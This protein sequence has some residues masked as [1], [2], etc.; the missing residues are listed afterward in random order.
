MSRRWVDTLRDVW[1]GIRSQPG[2]VGLAFTAIAVGI[3]SI[4]VLVT[5]LGGLQERSR[6]IVG[7]LGVNVVGILQH[8]SDP[9]AALEERHASLLAAN[10]PQS[11]VSTVSVLKVPTLG[12]EE[13]LSVVATDNALIDVRQWSLEDGRFLDPWDLTHRERKAVVSKTLSEQWNWKVGNVIM[14]RSTPFEV[15]GVVEVGGGALDGELG[16]AGLMLGERVVFVPK[17]VAPDWK[18]GRRTLP[19]G[20]AVRY[21]SP[22]HRGSRPTVDAIF[23]RAPSSTEFVHAVLTARR[24][25]SQPDYRVSNT[26]W[27]TPDS[28]IQGVAKLERTIGL[29]AGSIAVLCLLL[30]GTTLTSLMIANVSDRVVEIGLRRSLGATRW[31]IA[32]LFVVEA[33]VVTGAAAIVATTGTYLLLALGEDLFPVPLKLGPG[34]VLIPLLVAFAVGVLFSYWPARSAATIMPSEA[35]RNE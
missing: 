10:L 5:V 11:V 33:C 3:A 29:T 4:T 32:V 24:L 6:Q 7:E 30:G 22:D 26:S 35:L 28:L 31:E 9:R 12:T 16:D 23:I 27:V 13:L 2:R 34:S 17:T 15:V 8:G 19:P 18:A 14:L 1:D 25:L 21:R 20:L